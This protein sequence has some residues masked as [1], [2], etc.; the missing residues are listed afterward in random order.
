[1]AERENSVLFSLKELRTIED[2]RVRQ[3][4]E[5]VKAK[6]AA[7]AQAREA[8]LRQAKEEEERKARDEQERMH[9]LQAEKERQLRETELK[10]EG[11]KHRAQLEAQ[12]RLEEARI[13]AEVQAKAQ[14]Q[15]KKPPIVAIVGSVVG[16]VAVAGAV[17]GWVL[18]V[19]MPA[20]QKARDEA[21][22][23]EI[24]AMQKK[25]ERQMD[26]IK[27]QAKRDLAA[28]DKEMQERLAL[29]KTAE[30]QDKIKREGEEK[31]NAIK[32]HAR[33]VVKKAVDAAP[34]KPKKVGETKC[35]D[36]NDPLC[37]AGID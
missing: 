23:R 36:P 18:L 5:A 14:A 34:V 4:E 17:L 32:S 27:D 30:E 10:A 3:E 2:D 15:A 12:A 37:G 20:E 13:H 26:D 7:E 21:H 25:F 24:I 11:E 6:A 22:Q 29:A 1:M 8:A 35:K 28:A 31:K 9:R 33:E 16:V 19:K